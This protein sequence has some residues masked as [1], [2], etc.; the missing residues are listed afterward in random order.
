[1]YKQ[2]F[3]KIAPVENFTWMVG[4]NIKEAGS[5][6]S[7]IPDFSVIWPLAGFDSLSSGHDGKNEIAT[8]LS[9]HKSSRW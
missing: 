7:F 5:R 3:V 2:C 8:S 1:M 9:L 4:L 6:R